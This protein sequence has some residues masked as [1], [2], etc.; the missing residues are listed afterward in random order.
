MEKWLKLA[1]GIQDHLKRLQ[2]LQKINAIATF[3]RYKNFEALK[4]KGLALVPFCFEAPN[5]LKE[6]QLSKLI[7][8]RYIQIK[9]KSN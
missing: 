2:N 5:S 7:F 1:I 4:Y 6:N 3:L 9:Q 8:Y